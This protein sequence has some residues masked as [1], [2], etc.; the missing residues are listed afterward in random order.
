MRGVSRANFILGIVKTALIVERCQEYSR[1]A[2]ELNEPTSKLNEKPQLSYSVR[3]SFDR[4]MLLIK[5]LDR[6][7]L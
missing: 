5:L 6:Q 2:M 3:L 4:Q 1:W 7:I